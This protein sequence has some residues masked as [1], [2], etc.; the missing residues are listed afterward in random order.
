M[1]RGTGVECSP[2]ILSRGG[3]GNGQGC[4]GDTRDHCFTVYNLAHFIIPVRYFEHTFLDKRHTLEKP[5]TA[6]TL[7]KK[8][9]PTQ[10]WTGLVQLQNRHGISWSLFSP[11][12]TPW[13]RYCPI[14]QENII[15]SGVHSKGRMPWLRHR[16]CVFNA[17]VLKPVH[18]WLQTVKKDSRS[19]WTTRT[20]SWPPIRKSLFTCRSLQIL[21]NIFLPVQQRICSCGDVL[22]S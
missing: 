6:Q 12:C 5:V 19:V 21:E 18:V 16:L 20:L 15:Y 17:Q 11:S 8:V 14:G 4:T 22:A 3:I 10:P 13:W 1:G 7:R 9:K 2:G